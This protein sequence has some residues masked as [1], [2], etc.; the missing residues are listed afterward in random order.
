MR[1]FTALTSIFFRYQQ[2]LRYHMDHEAHGLVVETCRRYGDKDVL[3]W[4]QA[5]T[6]FSQHRSS[7][8]RQHIMQVL[9]H[10]LFNMIH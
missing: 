5:L 2:I 4:Q 8:C 9:A 3:L 1:H 7:D 6:Y 10:I